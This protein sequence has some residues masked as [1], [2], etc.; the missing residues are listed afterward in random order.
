MSN[1]SNAKSHFLSLLYP[2]SNNVTFKITVEL[3]IDHY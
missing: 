1:S 3:V 2:S